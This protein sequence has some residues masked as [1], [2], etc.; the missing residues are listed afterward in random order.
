MPMTPLGL[1]HRQ[2]DLDKQTDDRQ[3]DRCKHADTQTHEHRL[4]D[5]L[6][7]THKHTA[8]RK[9]KDRRLDRQADTKGTVT[10]STDTK[11]KW[12]RRNL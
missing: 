11:S 12:R 7:Q 2:T 1:I 8:T 4:T 9:H 3:T 5:R 6:A 10:D